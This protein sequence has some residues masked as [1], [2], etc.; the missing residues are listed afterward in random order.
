MN[1]LFFL[2]VLV[3][4]LLIGGALV[5]GLLTLLGWAIV[6]LVIGAIARLLVSGT[7][8]LGILRTVLAGIAGAVGGGLVAHALG[9][10]NLIEFLLAVLIAAV[11]VAAVA[12]TSRG[13]RPAR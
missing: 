2:L 8:G 4:V 6:G 3:V 1:V 10:G 5:G 7:G 13:P 9:L 11:V 12:G